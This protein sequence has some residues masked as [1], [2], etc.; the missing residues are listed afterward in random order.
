MLFRSARTQVAAAGEVRE[1]DPALWTSLRA[2]DP[3]PRRLDARPL[4]G[5]VAS[6]IKARFDPARILNPGVFGEDA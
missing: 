2:L 5:T 4:D 6:R 1:A 3:H